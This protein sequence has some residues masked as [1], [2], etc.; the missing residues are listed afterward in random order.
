MATQSRTLKLSILAETKKLSDA[1]KGSGKDVTTFG[2]QISAFGKKAALAFAAAGVA[3]GAFAKI[4]VS[5][6]SDLAETIS[7]V[8]VLFGSSAK[9]IEIFA[10]TA[11]KSLGQTKQ[12][13]LDAAATFAIFGTSAGLSGKELSQNFLLILSNLLLIFPHL[14]THHRRMQS[15]QLGQH[16]AGKPNHCGVM[17]FYS[18]THHSNKPP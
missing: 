5:S 4:A 3:F 7:K 9:E 8:G 12:Q 1:L 10:G 15:T 18:M 16:C 6:A 13:A 2:S 14:T 17:V 11:A